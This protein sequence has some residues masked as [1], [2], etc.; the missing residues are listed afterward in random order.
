[1]LQRA[2]EFCSDVKQLGDKLLS[3]LEKRD[4]EELAQMQ[5]RITASVVDTLRPEIVGEYARMQ[6]VLSEQITLQL[7][8]YAEQTVV[9]NDLQTYS[10]LS[11]LIEAIQAAQEQN[12]QWALSAMAALEQQRLVDQE[13]VRSD[14]VSFAVYTDKELQRTR[15]E[16]ESLSSKQQ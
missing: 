12:Q 11:Q 15:Q 13:Q 14:L 16:L 7:T 2:V 8:D 6:D 5:N 4:A 1:M 9:R 3:A 10:L